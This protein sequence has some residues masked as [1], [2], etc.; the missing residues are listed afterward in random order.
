MKS[1]AGFKYTPARGKREGVDETKGKMLKVRIEYMKGF[2]VRLKIS[3]IYLSSKGV[4]PCLVGGRQ[5]RAAV[6]GPRSRPFCLE[7]Q[8]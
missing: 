8:P 6:G 7:P 1:G 3:I 4:V 2:F 5:E